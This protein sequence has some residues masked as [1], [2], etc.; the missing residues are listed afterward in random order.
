MPIRSS[1][2]VSRGAQLVVLARLLHTSPDELDSLE[3]LDATDLA[4]LRERISGFL[5]DD[6]ACAYDKLR[7][8][9]SRVPGGL[10]AKAVVAVVPPDVTGRG[11][12]AL[13]PAGVHRASAVIR[14]LPP[15]YLADAAPFVDP[16]MIPVMSAGI[17]GSAFLPAVRELLRR[18]D[19]VTAAMFVENMSAPLIHELIGQV[20]ADRDVRRIRR[21]RWPLTA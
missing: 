21:T 16:R 10:V 5:S 11:C 6:I 20:E 18:E 19:F 12:G 8:L 17:D 1:F 15:Q 3:R 7:R 13:R 4:V 14:A 9:L 2:V